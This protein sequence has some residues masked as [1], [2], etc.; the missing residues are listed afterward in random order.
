[1]PTVIVFDEKNTPKIREFIVECD[2]L[3][4]MKKFKR[5]GMTPI[6]YFR[7]DTTVPLSEITSLI[8][9]VKSIATYNQSIRAIYVGHNMRK[10]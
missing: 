5:M 1:M 6:S 3:M 2:Q 7:P 10:M 9:M 8:K 4:Q